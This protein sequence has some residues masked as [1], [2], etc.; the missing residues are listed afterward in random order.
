MHVATKSVRRFAG[1]LMDIEEGLDVETVRRC[2]NAILNDLY[3]FGP[4]VRS[5]TEHAY[6]EIES[7]VK[8]K[9]EPY[10]DET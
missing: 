8:N 2:A 3:Y 7:F 10:A 6:E 5:Y 1:F 9:L 4:E